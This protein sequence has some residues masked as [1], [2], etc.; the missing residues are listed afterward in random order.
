MI[1][2][3]RHDAQKLAP[4]GALDL[5]YDAFGDRGRSTLLLIMGLGQQLIHWPED[6]CR[7]LAAE[8][9][10]V[11]RFDNRD[12]G[13]ST[14]LSGRRYSL[15]DMEADTVGLLDALA[16]DSAHV[17]GASLG[18]MIAQTMV[19]RHP[20]RVR[21]LASLMSTTGRRG[22]G[23]TSMRVFRHMLTRP[24]RTEQ[25][26]IERRVRVFATV[27]S[28]GFDQDLD[29]LRRVTA[30]AF[31]RDPLARDGRRRQHRAVRA[32][33]DRTE[34]LRHVTAPSVVVHGT[35]DP[36]CHFSGGLAT[37]QAIPGARLV[38]VPGMGH[39]LPRGAW[40]Q[41]ISAIASNAARADAPH[42]PDRGAQP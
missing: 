37:A 33:G 16:V 2:P 7:Q 20:D 39:D 14:H 24:P 8:G 18:A 1:G 21:S 23:R 41:L 34:A 13:R 4:V 36:M 42:V 38:L 35:M 30:A 6:F 22:V 25:E 27:G 10:R 26:A 5:C 17:V 40:P 32:A 28:T 3:M 11:V 19:I 9:F 15:E 12:A 29:E 31:R